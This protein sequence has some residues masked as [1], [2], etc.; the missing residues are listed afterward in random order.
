MFVCLSVCT[1]VT[2]YL[3][4]VRT[5]LRESWSVEWCLFA[6]SCRVSLHAFHLSQFIPSTFYCVGSLTSKHFPSLHPSLIHYNHLHQPFPVTPAT[7]R[8]SIK[9][10]LCNKQ[11]CNCPSVI[12]VHIQCSNLYEDSPNLS[13]T[14]LCLKAFKLIINVCPVN[15]KGLEQVSLLTEHQRSFPSTF[16]TLRYSLIFKEDKNISKNDIFPIN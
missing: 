15:L 1:L 8:D 2:C 5:I 7:L 12:T 3:R 4:C 13:N 6:I 11:M 14:I 9:R 10:T 16:F